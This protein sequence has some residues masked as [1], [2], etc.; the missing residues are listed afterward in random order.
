MNDY[1]RVFANLSGEKVSC[2]YIP[3]TRRDALEI[4]YT[5]LG[6]IAAA[7][8]N[9]SG[10]MLALFQ[11]SRGGGILTGA[12][13]IAKALAAVHS[14]IPFDVLDCVAKKILRGAVI[15]RPDK[16]A[17][18]DDL[19][20]TDYFDDRLDELLLATFWGLD[21]SYPRA[22]TKARTLLAALSEKAPGG[23]TS[24]ESSTVSKETK[25]NSSQSQDS[26]G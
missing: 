16:S 5:A 3:L 4:E 26:T 13:H 15:Q 2:T 18:I 1:H 22:F 10:H 23:T 6:T 9:A 12:E 7:L 14:A 24:K 25:P 19:H 21:V 8:S 11:Q 20:E 17:I